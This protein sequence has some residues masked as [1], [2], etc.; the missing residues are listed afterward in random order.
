[1]IRLVTIQRLLTM[2][3][4]VVSELRVVTKE[5]MPNRVT[6]LSRLFFFWETVLLGDC[7]VRERYTVRKRLIK[8]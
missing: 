3:E 1:M 8:L 7:S 4:R 5:E 2:I 6:V